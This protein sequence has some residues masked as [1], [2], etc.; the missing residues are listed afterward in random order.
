MSR[1]GGQTGREEGREGGEGR[2]FQ[3][4]ISYQGYCPAGKEEL[5]CPSV[6]FWMQSKGGKRG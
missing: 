2:V 3:E 6:T 5:R 4:E 1:K